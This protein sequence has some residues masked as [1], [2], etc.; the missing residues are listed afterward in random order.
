MDFN[1]NCDAKNQKTDKIVRAEKRSKQTNASLLEVPGNFKW[2]RVSRNFGPL[3][4][5]DDE[6]RFAEVP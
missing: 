3:G 2:V 5:E 4:T 6:R 1:E